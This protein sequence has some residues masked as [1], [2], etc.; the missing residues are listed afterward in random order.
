MTDTRATSA[1][2]T[3]FASA[4][5]LRIEPGFRALLANEKVSAR[6][7]YLRAFDR[8]AEH[9]RTGAY[10]LS[11][12]AHGSDIL[13]LRATNRLEDLHAATSLVSEAGLG[14]HLTPTSVTLGTL[15]EPPGP[16]GRFAVIVPLA[17]APPASALPPGARLALL[18]G[19]GL[20]SVPFTAVL[21]GDDALMGRKF[22]AGGPKAVGPVL[23]G[24]RA[25]IRDIVDHL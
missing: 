3:L 24:L 18:D 8:G 20:C 10:A 17:E 6:E 23:L 2:A 5:T 15:A 4:Q 22:L 7:D 14:R 25:E 11:G 19:R 16:A 12:L 21:E 9:V 13:I 1:D